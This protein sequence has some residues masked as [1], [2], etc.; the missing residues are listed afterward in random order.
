MEE[1]NLAA[2]IISIISLVCFVGILI[3][4]KPFKK[5]RYALL[6]FV[7]SLVAFG[8]VMAS[9]DGA[10]TTSSNESRT[11]DE[12]SWVTTER[13][14]RRTCP[15]ENCGIVGQL[16]FREGVE[17]YETQD[18]WVRITQPYD[19]SCVNGISEYVDAGNNACSAEN[20]ISGDQFSEW[21]SAAYLSQ[22]RPDD[23]GASATGD[24]TLVAGSDDFA[25]Y[26]TQFSAAAQQLIQRGRCSAQDFREMGGWVK[27]S[28]HRNEPVY[29]TYCGASH[30]SNRLYLN[31]ETGEIFQ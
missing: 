11:A 4:F 6:S 18:G 7:I 17:I 24:E 13:L 20:G 16:F 23:P 19:A 21:V 26:R 9:P 8:L 1:T 2:S 12:R 5:R 22:I 29:F 3:P 27:S 28:N 30:V 25:R 10:S 15:S 31:A 14:N